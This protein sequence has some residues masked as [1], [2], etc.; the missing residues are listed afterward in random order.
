MESS[1]L[2]ED[3]MRHRVQWFVLSVSFVAIGCQQSSDGST[4]AN[5]KASVTEALQAPS[6]VPSA[7]VAKP[8]SVFRRHGGIA[9]GLFRAAHDLDLAQAP[10]NALGTIEANLKAD[11]DGI[12]AAMKVFRADLV[13]GVKAGKLDSAKLTA[14]DGV[15][16]EAIANHKAKEAEALDSLH[17]LLDAAQRTTLVASVRAKQAER[18][19]R[20]TDWIKAKEADGAA[21]DWSKKRLDKLT[22]DLALDP[23]QQSQ[24]AA[25]LAKASDPPSRTGFQSRLDERQKRTDAL[26]TAFAGDTFDAKTL[27]LSI[28]PGKTAREPFDHIVAFVSKLLPILHP[29]QRDKFAA[30][31]DRPFGWGGHPG[32][33]GEAPARSPTDD[34]AFPFN[35]P[36]DNPGEARPAAAY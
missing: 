11:D 17:A 29:D 10:Q 8:R 21:P 15:V 30:S 13:V 31:L 36:I 35:E 16:E 1:F 22:A 25:I 19:S 26:L 34:I 12:R 9:S 7:A 33:S 32:V 3:S 4:G 24:V 28:L 18:E 20:M 14:D 6:A 2:K 27:D 23:A 5:A